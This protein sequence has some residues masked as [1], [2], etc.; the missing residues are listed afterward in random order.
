MGMFLLN[1]AAL[2]LLFELSTDD[3][4]EF[5]LWLGIDLC[6]LVDLKVDETSIP[7]LN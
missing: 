2:S 4:V 7:L 5:I 1:S 3:S 6:T